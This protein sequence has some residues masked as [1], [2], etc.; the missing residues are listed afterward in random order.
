LEEVQVLRARDTYEKVRKDF[1][2]RQDA[3]SKQLA[4]M[5]VKAPG[6]GFGDDTY[7]AEI[8]AIDARAPVTGFDKALFKEFASREHGVNLSS[9]PPKANDNKGK[10]IF[11]MS[12]WPFSA[13]WTLINDPI[14]R[15][16]RFIYRR[17]GAVFEKISHAMFAKYKDDLA[18]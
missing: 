10:I 18:A 11:W 9:F 8:A 15:L 17:L 12:Y 4:K 14:T 6:R 3:Y 2:S 7:K 1:V 5:N 13:T 16:Y